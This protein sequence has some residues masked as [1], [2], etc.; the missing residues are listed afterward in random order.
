LDITAN[1]DI[2]W[3][4]TATAIN[5]QRPRQQTSRAFPPIRRFRLADQTPYF[6]LV[7]QGNF[8]LI[9]ESEARM[10]Y[11]SGQVTLRQR[12]TH[13]LEYTLNYTW[14][15]SLTDSSG[16]YPVANTTMNGSTVQNGYDLNADWGPSGMDIRHSMNFVGVYHL[17]FGRGQTYGR[18]ANGFLEAVFGGWETLSLRFSVFR[19]SR[20][21]F[22]PEQQQ[23]RQHRRPESPKPISPDDHQESYYRKLVG[24]RSVGPALRAQCFK[25]NWGRQ[26]NLCVRCCG[27]QYLWYRA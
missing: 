5:L 14:A 9:T 19:I 3:R 17:P 4:T 2:T 11:N 20:H 16:N 12:P 27:F 25:S 1:T 18:A 13:G 24:N 15:K 8:V 7:G 6:S 23:H 21:S 22:R 26:W 10:N